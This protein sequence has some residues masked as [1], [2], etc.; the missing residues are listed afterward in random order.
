MTQAAP[1]QQPKRRMRLSRWSGYGSTTFDLEGKLGANHKKLQA[2]V[3]E[4]DKRW[5]LDAGHG[6]GNTDRAFLAGTLVF[7]ASEIN[8]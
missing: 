1:E 8:A 4:W 6:A 2:W 5:G 3:E 7:L